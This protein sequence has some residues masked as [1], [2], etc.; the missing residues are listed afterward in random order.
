MNSQ[1]TTTSVR[2]DKRVNFE[3]VE[4]FDE[5]CTVRYGVFRRSM[6]NCSVTIQIQIT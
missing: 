6:Q 3:M 5:I 2:I 1:L 4:Y